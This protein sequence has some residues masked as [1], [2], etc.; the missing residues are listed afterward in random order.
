VNRILW[1]TLLS[2][3]S[4]GCCGPA[5]QSKAQLSYGGHLFAIPANASAILS[6]G[7]EENILIFR[8]GADK[9]KRYLGFSDMAADRSLDW[10]CPLPVFWAAVFE[11]G[12]DAGCNKEQIDAFHKV[13]VETQETGVWSGENMTVYYSIGAEHSFLF[14]S[15]KAGK[16][17]KIDTDFLTK[18]ELQDLV[19]GAL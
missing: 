19:G 11:D 18:K 3:L 10:G 8:Y 14:V 13:F 6:T 9:G 16:A 5:T 4:L 17:L 2:L 15:D 12:A 7:D 1:A